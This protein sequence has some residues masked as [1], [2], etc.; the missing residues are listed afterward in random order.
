MN[1]RSKK[2][3]KNSTHFFAIKTTIM[4]ETRQKFGINYVYNLNILLFN[5]YD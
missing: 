1:V 3:K 2:K 5:N 4:Q